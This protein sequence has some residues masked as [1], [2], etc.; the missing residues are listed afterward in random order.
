MG[1]N[2]N[3]EYM[4][5]VEISLSVPKGYLEGFGVGWG[6]GV[7]NILC[8][9]AIRTLSVYGFFFCKGNIV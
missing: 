1:C 3:L 6:W 7:I 5:W 4:N 2:K 8:T 9:C